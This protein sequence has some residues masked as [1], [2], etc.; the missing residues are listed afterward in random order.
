MP[1]TCNQVFCG[2]SEPL[3]SVTARHSASQVV[4]VEK[5]YP[6]VKGWKFSGWR[7]ACKGK[8]RECVIDVA[9]IHANASGERN[10]KVG[11][12][13]VAVGPGLTRARPI[14][15]GT[16]APIPYTH[17]RLE[18][19]VNSGLQQVQL[20]PAPPAGSEY[21][22]ANITLTNNTSGFYTTDMGW[23]VKGRHNGTYTPGC[24]SGGPQPE[25]PIARSDRL[26]GGQSATGYV[27]WTIDTNDARTLELFFGGGHVSDGTTWF[28]LH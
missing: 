20:S 27:C 24:P 15:L 14:P 9:R 17:H 19:R 21:V 1:L 8:E 4:L 2:V 7:G 23:Q 16:T 28:A 18:L 6:Y 10:V 11:A 25:L 26:A 5:P 13:F 3:Q 22:A 12:A